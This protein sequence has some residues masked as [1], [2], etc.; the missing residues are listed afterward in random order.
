MH[1]RLFVEVLLSDLQQRAHTVHEALARNTA[2]HRLLERRHRHR[3]RRAGRQPTG[4][5]RLPAVPRKRLLAEVVPPPQRAWR[6]TGRGVAQLAAL[7][8]VQRLHLRARLEQWL[9]PSAA[10]DL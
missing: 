1:E 7:H 10:H 9:R 2:E 5:A 3:R 8:H 4:V 6:D